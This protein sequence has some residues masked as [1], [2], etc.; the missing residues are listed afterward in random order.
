MKERD[1]A[2]WARQLDRKL[3]DAPP[4]PLGPSRT[5]R[6]RRRGLRMRSGPAIA[7]GLGVGW[8]LAG[9]PEA[10]LRLEPAL[11]ELRVPTPSSPLP[12]CVQFGDAGAV[13]L[14][15]AC[16]WQ[17]TSP[18]MTVASFGDS[19]MRLADGM[20]TV[21]DGWL[22]FDV[23]RV[24]VGPPVRV[25]VAGGVVEVLGTRFSVYQDETR[26]H[27][28]LVE[29]R[30]RMLGDAGADATLQPGDRFTWHATRPGELQTAAERASAHAA[31]EAPA[32]RVRESKG[33]NE[34]IREIAAL[35]AEGRF[36]EALDL[37][38]R[39][40][41]ESRSARTREVLHYEAGTLIEGPMGD[42]S[43]ACRHWREHL[44]RYPKGRYTE[45]VALRLARLGCST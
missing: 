25:G 33:V 36:L 42:A 24:E 37:A 6:R 43:A 14:R 12:D 9:T 22:V 35:R 5:R 15:G 23:E 21:V 17:L 7:L 41:K 32:R 31:S 19:S 13:A 2:A 18:A 20:L 39:W 1:I 26:G 40:A 8:A 29:G 30:I 34:P 45:Q 27:V 10:P 3:T 38:R 4:P 11:V 28:E 16:A 44:A